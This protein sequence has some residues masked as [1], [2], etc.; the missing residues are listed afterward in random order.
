MEK[1]NSINNFVRER[2][3]K[4]LTNIKELQARKFDADIEDVKNHDIDVSEIFFSPKR[5]TDIKEELD[6]TT[7]ELKL[8][9]AIDVEGLEFLT[10]KLLPD[11]KAKMP[12]E[13]YKE[14][15]NLAVELIDLSTKD[16]EV[17]SEAV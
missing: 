3:V 17:G 4:V 12:E 1:H 11:L 7:L 2:L 10:E 8:L 16:I 15:E 14:I 13:H 5:H 6:K 9:L